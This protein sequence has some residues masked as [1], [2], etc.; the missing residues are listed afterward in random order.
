ME[1]QY[2]KELTLL[3]VAK[4][5]ASHG[6]STAEPE[7]LEALA[8][9]ARNYILNVSKEVKDAVE[10]YGRTTPGVM[11]LLSVIDKQV[12][13]CCFNKYQQTH[14]CVGTTKQFVERLERVQQT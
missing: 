4:I 10:S 9:A 14:Q 5:A 3:A 8:D 12:Y 13:C 2:A 7:A 11:D 1:S 6:Y